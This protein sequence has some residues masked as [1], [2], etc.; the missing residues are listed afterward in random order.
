MRVCDSSPVAGSV[1]V[2]FFEENP[3]M[4]IAFS[5]LRTCR[6]SSCHLRNPA[7]WVASGRWAA[8]SR[9]FRRKDAE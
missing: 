9:M 7:T 2:T 3:K 1:S 5:P 4:Q 8:I 6:P